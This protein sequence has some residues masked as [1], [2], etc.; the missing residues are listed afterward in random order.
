MDEKRFDK[1]WMPSL[2]F[3][4]S[5]RRQM[6]NAAKNEEVYSFKVAY[7]IIPRTSESDI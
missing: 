1:R 6:W 2:Y 4:T 7:K 3:K 5:V